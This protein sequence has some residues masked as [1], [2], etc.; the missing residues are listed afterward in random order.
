MSLFDKFSKTISQFIAPSALSDRD[1][2][3]LSRLDPNKIYV[4]NVRSLL[5]I[6][7]ASA[8]RILETA[9]RQGIFERRVEVTCPDG[10]VAA[11]AEAEDKLPATVHCWVE[12]NG[13]LEETDLPTDSL[14]KTVFYRLDGQTN[15]V[16][17]SRTA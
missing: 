4:E 17:Y 6:S 9:V 5:G 3:L 16:P 14:A 12:E 11:S 7:Q 15:P 13:H 8:V 2:Q 1:I 10:S